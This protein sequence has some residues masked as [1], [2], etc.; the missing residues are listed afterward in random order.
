[1]LSEAKEETKIVF[2]GL[3]KADSIYIENGNENL[4][5]DTGLKEDREALI[6][7]LQALRVKKLDYVLLTHPDKDHIGGASYVLEHF[8]IGELIQSKH[9]K[10][11]K[12]EARI[13]K[14]VDQK[15][16]KN[17]IATEDQSFEVG[18]LKVNVIVPQKESYGQ[19]ND[20]SLITL[21]EDGDLNYLFGGDAEEERLAELLPL[22]LPVIDLYKVAHHGRENKN[23]EAFIQKIVPKHAVIT[24]FNETSEIDDLLRAEGTTIRHVFDTDL[25]VLSDGKIVKIK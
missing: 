13:Q 3:G 17:T 10:G 9:F 5:I 25:T 24:N 1:M 2:F 18:T 7:K 22:D 21:I 23:S 4:L 8:Q 20:Y 12:R 15:G 19:D 16:I 6:L 11:T 14:V